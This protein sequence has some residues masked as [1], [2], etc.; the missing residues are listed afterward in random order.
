MNKLFN[1]PKPAIIAIVLFIMCWLWMRSCEGETLFTV[2]AGMTSAEFS[3]STGIIFSER[4]NDKWQVDLVLIGEQA[5]NFKEGTTQIRNNFSIGVS[6]IVMSRHKRFEL[7]LGVAKWQ[8][9]SRIF[10]C[11]MTFHLNL[12]WNIQRRWALTWDHWS[13]AGT[14]TPNSGQELISIRYKFR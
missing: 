13:N 4:F 9:T 3:D 2:G 11:D 12:A 6:R 8:N 10:G 7:G 1:N 5:G 14:C